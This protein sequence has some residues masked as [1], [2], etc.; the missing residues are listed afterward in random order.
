L[1]LLFN[2]ASEYIRKIYKNQMGLKLNG[3][4]QLM[5]YTDDVN[6]VGNN[7]ETINRNT[8][9]LIDASKKL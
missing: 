9:P 3:T 7:I 1:P 6:V 5:D 8:E 4:H 2:F